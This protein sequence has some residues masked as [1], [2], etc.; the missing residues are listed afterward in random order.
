MFGVL[1][2]VL[3]FIIYFAIRFAIDVFYPRLSKRLN[4]SRKVSTMIKSVLIILSWIVA[5][6]FINMAILLLR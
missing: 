6:Y 2:L 1:L 5:L 4:L 3:I